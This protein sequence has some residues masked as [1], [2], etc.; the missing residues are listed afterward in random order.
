LRLA[1]RLDQE[2]VTIGEQ[3]MLAIA[4]AMT[5]NPT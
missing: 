2:A 4:R 5:P 1:E 3:Q